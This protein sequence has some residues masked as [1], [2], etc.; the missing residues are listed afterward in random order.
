MTGLTRRALLHAASVA[1]SAALIGARGLRAAT[2]GRSAFTLG[3]ASGEPTPDGFVLWTR[4]APSPLEA[5]G[6][7]AA[8]RV[9]VRW[10][11]SATERFEPIRSGAAVADPEWGHSV[12]VELAGLEPG[13]PYWYRF[14]A[15]GEASPIGRTRTAPAAS[16]APERLR[17][18]FASCQNWEAGFYAAYRH[19]AA[20]DPDLILFLGD[21]IYES[22][23]KPG[24]VRMHP[25][26]E[27]NDLDSYRIRYASYKGDPLLQAAH[28]IAPWAT[29][30]DDHEV[31]NNYADDLDQFNGDPAAFLKRRADAYRAYYEHMPLPAAQRPDGSYL[32][33]YR[34]LDWGRLAQ[35][36]IVDDRQFRDPPPCQAPDAIARH[37]E[38]K[39]YK[40]DCAE[41][42][43]PARSIL[44]ADQEAWLMDALGRSPARWNLLT[45]QTLMLPWEDVTPGDPAGPLE[46]FGTD[47]WDGYPA[48]RARILRRWRDA[49]TPNP[50]ILSGDI[51]SFVAGDHADPDDPE[52]I[53]A[54][55]FVGGSITSNNH[56]PTLPETARRN[57]G[58]R[59]TDIVHRGYGLADIT[60]DRCDVRFR[61]LADVRDPNSSIGD[62]AR[63]SVENGRA[64]LRTA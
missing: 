20:D 28:L 46:L 38:N 21:Y 51:H 25:A 45:Q 1:G 19:M 42:R 29:T 50:V 35:F 3:V 47:T 43:D 27:A 36:Q 37:L 59:F 24:G 44:G 7:M 57:P 34:T 22:A 64:G 33:L 6:G 16:A 41:R 56:H 5:D 63:F 30:W 10:E 12:H 2:A 39:G 53:V 23:A 61:G 14:L 8:Q 49:K 60:A 55:E 31:A 15:G 13:R 9:P 48:S 32:R 26:A 4:L 40:P 58:F 52:R 62:L 17:I 11:V 54:S 18:A